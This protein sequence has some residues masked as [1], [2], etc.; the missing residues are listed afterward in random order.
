MAAAAPLAWGDPLQGPLLTQPFD[1]VL[2]SDV[3]YQQEALPLFVRTFADLCATGAH[4]LLCCERR[5]TLPLPTALFEGAG[6]R[7]CAVPLGEQH[8]EW[9]SEDIELFEVQ[10]KAAGGGSSS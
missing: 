5:P 1:L 7:L 9:R 8:P 3:L 2:A 4:G 6:L 10:L